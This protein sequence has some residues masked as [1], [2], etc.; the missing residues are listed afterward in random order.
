MPV[1]L[2]E[3]VLQIFFDAGH[4][5]D[6][7]QQVTG[8]VETPPNLC[9]GNRTSS[10]RCIIN[11]KISILFPVG[12]GRHDLSSVG[13]QLTDQGSFSSGLLL[14]FIPVR[15][16]LVS[17]GDSGFPV[18]LVDDSHQPHLVIYYNI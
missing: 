13:V 18:L 16:V 2:R 17:V 6:L 10:R 11:L 4:F 8:S 1:V 14:L 5:P 9:Y 7:I 15:F 3:A 12:A